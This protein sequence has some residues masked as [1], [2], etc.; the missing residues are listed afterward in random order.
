VSVL[1]FTPRELFFESTSNPRW[2]KD[3]AIQ[4]FFRIESPSLFQ[5]N[6]RPAY[7]VPEQPPP[8]LEKGSYCVI[9]ITLPVN[10]SVTNISAAFASCAMLVGVIRQLAITIGVAAGDA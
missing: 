1:T 10:T 9:L 7:T 2:R 4:P 5:S 6:L 8:D 3:G